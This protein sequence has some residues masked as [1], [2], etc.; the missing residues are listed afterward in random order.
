MLKILSITK[1]PVTFCTDLL[2]NINCKQTE[3]FVL[4]PNSSVV[5]KPAEVVSA[6]PLTA[7]F[8]PR[9]ITIH[10]V[11]RITAAL[12]H[13]TCALC[14]IAAVYLFNYIRI[15]LITYPV[16]TQKIELRIVGLLGKLNFRLGLF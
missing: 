15:G 10:T 1:R 12:C 9:I 16:I 4:R 5:P 13:W 3:K 11:K 6:S 14:I 7:E 2:Y 8:P